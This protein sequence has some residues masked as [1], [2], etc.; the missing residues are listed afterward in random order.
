MNPAAPPRAG[1]LVGL[2]LAAAIG[3][4]RLAA[5]V[6]ARVSSARSVRLDHVV[7][8]THALSEATP[9]IP[10]PGVTFPFK[11]TP[12]AT[13]KT[14]GVAAYRWDI[15]EH[16]GTQIDAPSHFF[17]DGR[18]IEAIEAGELIAPLA[19]IDV[20]TRALQDADAAVTVADVLAWEK[21][22]GRIPRGAAVLCGRA[23]MPGS[24]TPAPS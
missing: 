8:L 20:R 15:H 4:D 9:F 16:I 22:H 7:D 17:A 19:V 3:V 6:E 23:G 21:T 10:V 24:W 18:S 5:R 13:I 11:M 12:I 14:H 1:L 2:A